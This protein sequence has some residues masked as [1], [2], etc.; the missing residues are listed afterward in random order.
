MSLRWFHFVRIIFFLE[1]SE[2]QSMKLCIFRA[3]REKSADL[4]IFKRPEHACQR[5]N[6]YSNHSIVCWAYSSLRLRQR[7]L[8]EKKKRAHRSPHLV[9]IFTLKNEVEK[10]TRTQQALRQLRIGTS[11][12]SCT[13]VRV[14]TPH[15][16]NVSSS[17]WM[18]ARARSHDRNQQTQLALSYTRRSLFSLCSRP[19]ARRP[20]SVPVSTFIFQ[21]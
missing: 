11:S 17:A 13:G 18:R 16:H 20:S 2:L 3:I 7:T 21:L 4:M 15:I 6:L 10:Y 9:K 5:V 14:R 12:Y 8:N 19:A 1:K